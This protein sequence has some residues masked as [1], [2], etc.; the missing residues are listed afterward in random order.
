MGIKSDQIRPGPNLG[1]LGLCGFTMRPTFCSFHVLSFVM[2]DDSIFFM[3]SVPS[4]W[5]KMGVLLKGF[6]VH[7]TNYENNCV[8]FQG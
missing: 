4:T 8:G 2:C 1:P 5:K 3:Q 7:S 6:K